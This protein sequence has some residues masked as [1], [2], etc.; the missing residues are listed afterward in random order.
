MTVVSHGTQ[1]L[2]QARIQKWIEL[3]DRETQRFE[4]DERRLV[5]S[6]G[7]AMAV[8]QARRFETGDRIAQKIAQKTRR[9]FRPLGSAA[10]GDPRHRS[11]EAVRGKLAVLFDQLFHSLAFVARKQAGLGEV[12]RRATGHLPGVAEVGRS[13]GGPPA[14][15]ARRAVAFALAQ[16]G[17]P[18]RW[19]GEGPGSFDCSGL[20]WAAWRAAGLAW[21][22]LAADGQ[23]RRG[24]RVHGRLRPG[25]L[26]FFHTGRMPAGHAGH[27][28][29]YLDAGRMVVADRYLLANVVYQG[30][31]G[32]LPPEELWNVGTLSTGGLLPDLTFVLDVPLELALS[33]R[34]SQ[35]DR[36]ES[37]PDAFHMRV[38]EGF[39]AEARRRP[40]SI[41]IID[42]ARP[43]GQVQE[44][45]RAA[46]VERWP[47]LED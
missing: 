33:R 37:R 26:L 35:T 23:W 22:R 36:L 12:L 11:I 8:D 14:P 44:E 19:G 2:K 31:A 18:Y 41:I 10:G 45:I 7:R 32:G 28:G 3:V 24:P 1:V 20:A 40:E 27:V 29:V 6:I 17:K 46:F 13:Q 4:H 30:H 38:R 47:C 5:D 16:R 42:A 25:D 34:K 21:P 9:Y 39:L 15:G 43:V